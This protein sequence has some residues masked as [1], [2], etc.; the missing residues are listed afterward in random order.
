MTKTEEIELYRTFV[1]SLP[2]DSYLA[3]LLAGTIPLVEATIRNDH[4]F[5]CPLTEVWKERRESGES[6]VVVNKEIGIRQ[7][8]LRAVNDE[9]DRKVRWANEEVSRAKRDLS[10]IQKTAQGIVSAMIRD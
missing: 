4:C 5:P 2:A 8:F 7:A 6:L 1:E 9:S 10:T 3:D